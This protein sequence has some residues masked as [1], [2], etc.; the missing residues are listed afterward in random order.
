MVTAATV[1]PRTTTA[2]H[3][4]PDPR[5]ESEERVVQAVRSD[6]ADQAGPGNG[7]GGEPDV[8]RREA[9]RRDDPEGEAEGG[10]DE[11]VERKHVAAAERGLR[12]SR[13]RGVRA[14]SGTPRSLTAE[15]GGPAAHSG[16]GSRCR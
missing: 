1:Y 5:N 4:A 8:R 3:P 6:A 11:T 12:T 2:G 16:R 10:A 15:L 14:L 9:V 13:K 7:R